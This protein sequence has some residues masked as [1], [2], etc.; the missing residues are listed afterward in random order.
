MLTRIIQTLFLA[1]ML[2]SSSLISAQCVHCSAPA[3]PAE[4]GGQFNRTMYK[5]AKLQLWAV[6]PATAV[7]GRDWFKVKTA[8]DTTFVGSG[9]T[10]TVTVD[11]TCKYIAH[12]INLCTC[13]GT[14]YSTYTTMA[15]ITVVDSPSVPQ[16][17]VN[18]APTICSGSQTNINFG[19]GTTLSGIGY[20]Y[21]RD[22]T[23][24]VS[25]STLG[26]STG[27]PLGITLTNKT[28]T[29]Q[30]VRFMVRM[31]RSVGAGF[32][33]DCKSFYITVL[34]DTP[35]TTDHCTFPSKPTPWPTGSADVSTYARGAGVQFLVDTTVMAS[36]VKWY[37]VVGTDTSYVGSGYYINATIDTAAK[38]IARNANTCTCDSTTYYSDYT[39]VANY[40]VSNSY[41]STVRPLQ[42]MPTIVSGTAIDII[43]R[44]DTTA[45]VSMT[46]Y[47]DNANV[48]GSFLQATQANNASGAQAFDFILTNTTNSPQLVRYNIRSQ[49]F[50]GAFGNTYTGY[51]TVLPSSVTAPSGNHCKVPDRTYWASPPTISY[52]KDAT[53]NLDLYTGASPGASGAIP[54]IPNVVDSIEW[55]KVRGPGDTVYVGSATPVNTTVDTSF[56]VLAVSRNTCYWSDSSMHV[57]KSVP[58]IVAKITKVSGTAGA[59]TFTNSK[60]DV[61]NGTAASITALKSGLNN[62]IW[63]RS[64][65]INV[66]GTATG[67]AGSSTTGVTITPTL[68][69]T[70][71][72]PQKVYFV[73]YTNPSPNY[74]SHAI[75][76]VMVYPACAKWAGIS[77]AVHAVH[78]SICAGDTAT[79]TA[80]TIPGY[81]NDQYAWSSGDTTK[82]IHPTSAGTY[83]VTV[84]NACGCSATASKVLVVKS[85]PTLTVTSDTICQRDTATLAATASGAAHYL[86]STGDST[87]SVSVMAGGAYTVTVTDSAHCTASAT[88]SVLEYII[89]SPMFA[90]QAV[91]SD[92]PFTFIFDHRDQAFGGYRFEWALDSSFA[93]LHSTDSFAITMSPDSFALIWLR[94]V[95]SLTGC[96]SDPFT[97]IAI[98]KHTIGPPPIDSFITLCAGSSTYIAVP[99]SQI[100]KRYYIGIDSIVIDSLMGTGD[101]IQLPTGAV[102]SFATF[103]ITAADTATH[104]ITVIDSGIFVRAYPSVSA[105]VFIFGDTVIYS[106]DTAWT[107]YIAI[108]DGAKR[109][110]YS[111]VDSGAVIDSLTGCVSSVTHSFTVRAHAVGLPGCGDQ[112]TDRHIEVN[113]IGFPVIP[114]IYPKVIDSPQVVSFSVDSILAGANADQIEWS[115]YPDFKSSE[116]LSSPAKISAYM[117]APGDTVIYVRSRYSG[118]GKV[119]EKV[120]NQIVYHFALLSAGL[121]DKS[122]WAYDANISDEFNTYISQPNP[123]Q[124]YPGLASFLGDPNRKWALNFFWNGDPT[125]DMRTTT[126]PASCGN[127][128]INGDFK[129]ITNSGNTSGGHWND[130]S[131]G[132][133]GEVVFPIDANNQS[134]GYADIRASPLGDTI[135]ACGNGRVCNYKSGALANYTPLTVAA[136]SLMEIRLKRP[137]VAGAYVQAGIWDWRLGWDTILN[138]SIGGLSDG[139]DFNEQHMEGYSNCNRAFDK[140]SPCNYAEDYHT[141]SWVNT[142]N[143]LIF[144]IDGKEMWSEAMDP[145][146]LASYASD[147]IYKGYL[148]LCLNVSTRA[149]FWQ[150]D[151]LIDYIRWYTPRASRPAN[152]PPLQNFQGS[153]NVAKTLENPTYPTS[154]QPN[155][156]QLTCTLNNRISPLYNIVPGHTLGTLSSFTSTPTIFYKSAFN[157]LL[158][159]HRLTGNIWLAPDLSGHVMDAKDFI[160]PVNAS[161]VYFQSTHNEL[162]YIYSSGGIW[163]EAQAMD[164][165]RLINY[166]GGYISMDNAGR[167][168]FKGTD[169]H[170]W[171]WNSHNASKITGNGTTGPVEGALASAQCGCLEFYRGAGNTLHQMYWWNTWHDIGAVVSGNVSDNIVLDEAHSR[172]YFIGLD[173]YIYYYQYSYDRL[174][175]SGLVRLGQ[176]A[177]EP[178]N[179]SSQCNGNALSDLVLSSDGQTLYYKGTDGT[180]WYYFNDREIRTFQSKD[181]G[182]NWNKTPLTYSSIQGPITLTKVSGSDMLLYAGG[183]QYIYSPSW[184]N[185]DINVNCSDPSVVSSYK[186]K[187]IP[188]TADTLSADSTGIKVYPNPS[189]SSFSIDI[190]GLSSFATLELSI[191][192]I[193]GTVVYKDNGHTGDGIDR[194]HFIWDATAAGSGLYFYR[195]RTSDGRRYSGKMVKL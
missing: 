32:Y 188:N 126:D 71:T 136:P 117:Y 60:L 37:K 152:Q 58:T 20:Q 160:T 72:K 82:T 28:G 49:L 29:S 151:L 10:L 65:V 69:D 56:S 125:V 104:I 87:S 119:S 13:G 53:I 181:C 4:Y 89:T 182:P 97:T 66:T 159:T 77:T 17:W 124:P 157:T 19:T 18:Y 21:L 39:L 79:L 22:D 164:G 63:Y 178:G 145:S 2:F 23:N 114:A 134:L 121:L 85:L 122:Q 118:T 27:G 186:N 162:G 111:I 108:A 113:D 115:F 165:H 131:E 26:S 47:R 132:S 194:Y 156:G 84:T 168:I 116:I 88:G 48:T 140:Y 94:N 91:A 76:S 86:W 139:N 176:N 68:S 80:D 3:A 57:Y 173:H 50:S 74:N 185:A 110:T 8:G 105:P 158:Q 5:N 147:P 31:T 127:H 55:Y 154:L 7:D 81:G 133:G 62:Y 183:D 195:L 109:L 99:A 90:P 189:E 64:N 180:L 141:L 30:V 187:P 171:F 51:L 137:L 101:T 120:N 148:S 167:N 191:Q 146:L 103:T 83:T 35:V 38:Y 190:K 14:Y 46:I 92:T 130:P 67:T 9:D 54:H 33:F 96:V 78:D 93:S 163:T 143:E 102:D 40:S 52:I 144:F 175:P 1:G 129:E 98:L 112:S 36:S 25:G 123:R 149:S 16:Y 70:I 142:G 11:T 172:V 174:T 166:C 161:L 193:D 100:G 150:A 184:V 12:N 34:P 42:Y 41:I 138:G 73:A 135:L 155:N 170:I 128:F 15:N 179:A 95:D 61:C 75:T 24:N 192:A 153:S 45:L 43:P 177:T 107:C 44:P 6:K 169:K 59:P 106:G